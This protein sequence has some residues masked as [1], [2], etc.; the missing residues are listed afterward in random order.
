[1]KSRRFDDAIATGCWH[2][3]LH[4]NKDYRGSADVPWPP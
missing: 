4:P 1:M 3:D 2:L